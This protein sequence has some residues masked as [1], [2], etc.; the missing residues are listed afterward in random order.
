MAHRGYTRY[1]GRSS[2]LQSGGGCSAPAPAPTLQRKRPQEPHGR[3]PAKGTHPSRLGPAK[4]H[5]PMKTENAASI[6]LHPTTAQG[7][8]PSP[9]ERQEP[10]REPFRPGILNSI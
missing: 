2:A 4:D 8:A 6:D 10:P 3:S 7:N 1:Y 5:D 9:G